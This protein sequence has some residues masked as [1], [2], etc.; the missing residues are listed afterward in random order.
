MSIQARRHNI[1]GRIGAAAKWA[2]R[3]PSDITLV[4]VTKRQSRQAVQQMLE[5]GHTIFGENRV[6]EAKT[7]WVETLPQYR[8]DIELRLIGPL[9]TNKAED[10]V[11]LFNVIETLDREKLARAILKA[12]DKV[13]VMPRL[14]VQ[15]NVGEEPQKSGIIPSQ[16]AA[17]LKR[18]K[19]EYDLIPDG[20][21]CIPPLGEAPSPYFWFLK[22]LALDHDISNL[23]MGM[24]ADYEVAVKMGATHIR[25]GTALFGPR[26]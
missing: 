21:M 17:F 10:A 23:S 22:N 6:Q 8:Q 20:L 12:A 1:L 16:L 7:R 5:A 3:D 11:R 13:G 14:F 18:L 19:Q 25:V 9:Q 26:P 24:S 4:A 15:V 2:K